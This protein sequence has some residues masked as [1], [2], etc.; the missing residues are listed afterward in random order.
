MVTLGTFVLR[1]PAGFDFRYWRHLATFLKSP[2]RAVSIYRLVFND[3]RKCLLICSL[4]TIVV[5]FISRFFVR[6]ECG[7]G[8]ILFSF[9]RTLEDKQK[10]Y[11]WP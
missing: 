10:K 8:G 6:Y 1:S 2:I 11:I 4:P 7:S 9:A 5:E 3:L